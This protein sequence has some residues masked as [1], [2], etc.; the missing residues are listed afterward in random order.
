LLAA[1]D[2]FHKSTDGG[3]SCRDVHSGKVAITVWFADNVP[4]NARTELQALG[5][6]LTK[7]P[8]AQNVVAGVLSLDKLDDLAKL[9][10]VRFVSF[11]R[12]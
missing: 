9:H 3:A 7:G 6:G 1:L 5:F 10:F 4:A 2:C 11:Q 8:V 12:R